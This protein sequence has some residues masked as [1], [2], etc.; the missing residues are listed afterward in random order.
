VRILR[1]SDHGLNGYGN[2]ILA[3]Q[4]LL[5][6]N[7]EAVRRF[8]AICCRAWRESAADPAPAIAT[9]RRLSS[10]SDPALE[11][12]RLEYVLQHHVLSEA[13][14]REGIGSFEPARM[15]EN[16]RSVAT[17]FGLARTPSVAEI[18][19]AAFMPPQA[20]RMVRA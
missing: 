6:G 8:V 4:P 18:F 7:P 16:I 9:L 5:R 20:E 12:E 15:E 19:D 13:A 2:A 11:R 3:G 17:G 10:L 14:R 1:Y